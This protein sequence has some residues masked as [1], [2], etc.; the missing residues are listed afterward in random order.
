VEP[1]PAAIAWYVEEAQ[2]LLEEQQRRAESLRTRAG[3][4]A[5]FGAAVLALVGGNGAQILEAAAGSARLAIGSALIV[6]VICLAAA[7]GVAIWGVIKPWPFATLAADEIA[8]Y[9][10]DRFLAE[11]DLWR[12][13]VRS[14]RTLEEVTREAQKDGNAAAR[15]ITVS[16]YSLL[17]GLGFSLVS[18]GTLIFELI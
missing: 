17:A 18:L 5:G 9:T 14:L 11:P 7:V 3:H 8:L 15:A 4:L 6:A 16:L 2:R 10:S 13:Q 1:N 12:V